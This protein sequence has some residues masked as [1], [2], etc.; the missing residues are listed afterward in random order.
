MATTRHTSR[1]R[2]LK[3][4]RSVRLHATGE[5]L[6]RDKEEDGRAR[7]H[8][9]FFSFILSRFYLFTTNITRALSLEAIKG[10]AEAI[11][12]REKKATTVRAHLNQNHTHHH[13]QE[14]WDLLPLSKSL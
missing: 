5:L 8:F 10:E 4:Q 14:T 6:L 13:S 11:S 9:L 3:D 12:K 2:E 7:G 1:W